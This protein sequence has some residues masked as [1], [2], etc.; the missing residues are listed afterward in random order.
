M[1]VTFSVNE[2]DY[3]GDIMEKGIYLHFN[4]TRIKVADTI[5]EYE[6]L[7]DDLESIVD[8]LNENNYRDRL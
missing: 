6:K 4:N 7:V 2:Y 1:H 8:E 5:E 3:E